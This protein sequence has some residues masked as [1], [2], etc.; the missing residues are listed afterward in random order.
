MNV[1][2]IVD[3]KVIK[4]GTLKKIVQHVKNNKERTIIVNKF[5]INVGTIV[6]KR[7]IK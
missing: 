1:A 2:I 4:L 3:S 5:L 6:V 7:I